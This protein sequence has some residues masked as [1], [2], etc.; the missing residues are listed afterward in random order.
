MA[1]YFVAKR[2]NLHDSYLEFRALAE[3]N[4]CSCSG[5][6]PESMKRPWRSIWGIMKEQ[7]G[8]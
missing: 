2:R 3:G 1:S 4:E 5:L 7:R 6:L 8:G